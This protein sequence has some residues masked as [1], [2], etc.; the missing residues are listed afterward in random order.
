ML[1]LQETGIF[2]T[3]FDLK[4]NRL[5]FFLF[6]SVYTLQKRVGGDIQFSLIRQ[7]Q[8]Q[9]ESPFV[10]IKWINTKH[11]LGLRSVLLLSL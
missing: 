6:F 11:V 2:G 1:F 4:A 3:S 7:I 10:A 9:G 8:L 5:S